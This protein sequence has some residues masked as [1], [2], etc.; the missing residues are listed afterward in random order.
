MTSRHRKPWQCFLWN[1]RILDRLVSESLSSQLREENIRFWSFYSTFWFKPWPFYFILFFFFLFLSKTL[2]KQLSELNWGDQVNVWLEIIC[3]NHWFAA[4]VLPSSR[5]AAETSRCS[6]HPAWQTH[7]ALPMKNGY[8]ICVANGYHFVFQGNSLLKISRLQTWSH[9][10]TSLLPSLSGLTESP[11]LITNCLFSGSGSEWDPA[12]ACWSAKQQQLA[13][14]V[15]KLETMSKSVHTT[16]PVLQHGMRGLG[17]ESWCS[18]PKGLKTERAILQRISTLWEVGPIAFSCYR[19]SHHDK[20][21]VPCQQLTSR[22]PD[23]N[24]VLFGSQSQSLATNTQRCCC[25]LV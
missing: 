21:V 19:R 25:F 11:T 5:G 16:H 4:Q 20:G 7:W 8:G 6:K 14:I 13:S 9:C 24:S 18:G 2:R 15:V 1:F 23:L 17:S 3:K 10:E 12:S 22:N